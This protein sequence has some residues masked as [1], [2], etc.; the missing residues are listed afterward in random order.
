MKCLFLFLILLPNNILAK[1][2]AI[3][4]TDDSY[5]GFPSEKVLLG[6]LMANAIQIVAWL[7]NQIW[8]LKNKKE[9][10]TE[11]KLEELTESSHRLE[12]QVKNLTER[13]KDIPDHQDMIS[14]LDS[15]IE[16]KV[17]RILREN[18]K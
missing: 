13:I 6:I 14:A 9:D 3:P 7:G 8:S 10:K 1:A 2:V 16:L 12:E 4:I 5:I 17:L 11:G 18:E 15:R